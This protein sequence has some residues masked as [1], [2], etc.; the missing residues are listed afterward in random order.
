VQ[1]YVQA[2]VLRRTEFI[3]CAGIGGVNRLDA[4]YTV[5]VPTLHWLLEQAREFWDDVNSRRI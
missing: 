5:H 4:H 3:I 2:Y 1:A